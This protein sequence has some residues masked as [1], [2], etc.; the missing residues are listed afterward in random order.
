MT[1]NDR[2]VE[3]LRLSVQSATSAPM[4]VGRVTLMLSGEAVPIEFEVPA[5]PVLARD[6]LPIME[7]L[8]D[9][10][11]ARAERRS[12]ASGRPISC[13]AGCG[14]CC[15]QPVPVTGIEA[16]RLAR[17][18]EAMPEPRRSEIRRRFDDAV[19]V[20]SAAGVLEKPAVGGHR[21]QALRYFR[22]GVPCPFLEAESCSIHPQRPLACRE[23]LVTSPPQNC[24]DPQAETIAMVPLDAA[25]SNALAA[26]DPDGGWL[27]LVLA[28]QFAEGPEAV[29]EPRA[30]AVM[31]GEALRAL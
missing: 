26:I 12:V 31:L 25:A 29:E 10:M 14:A 6:L 19:A 3:P 4:V 8:A 13:A 16:R 18:V 15:R 17:L 30:A 11:T 20:L 9:A 22:M 24:R 1:K 5:A 27:L 7:G 21:E 28:L 2:A 23:Y